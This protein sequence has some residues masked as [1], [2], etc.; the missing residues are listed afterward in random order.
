MAGRRFSL[1][2][3]LRR[4]KKTGDPGT[5]PAQQPEEMQQ[6]QPLQEDPGRVQTEEQDHAH[7]RFHR[8]AQAFLKFLGIR[9]TKTGRTPTEVMAQPDPMPK[10]LKAK[11]DVGTVSTDGTATC[12]TAVTDELMNTDSKP[13]QRLADAPSLD[14]VEES[15]VSA[16]VAVE[17]DR[18]MEQRP[19]RV[20]KLAWLKEGEEESP[21]P[22]PAQHPE[23]VEQFQP[24]QEEPGRVQTEEQDRAH[25]RFHR[26]A[27][28]FLKFL[29]IRRRKTGRTP[30]EVMAQ[31]DPTPKEL[32]AKPD[33]G[34][35]STDGT[36]TC[37]TAVTDELMNTDSKPVQRLADAPSLDFVEESV[38]SAQVAVEPDRGM[39]QRPPRVPKLAWLK[40]GEEESPG[41]APAQH[42]EDVEQFQPLQEDPGQVQTEEQDHAHGRFHRAA[43]AFLKFLGIRRTKT[44]RTPTEVM[45]QP[46][47]MPKELKAKPDVGTVSTDGTATCDTAVTD[48]L[49]NTDSKPV[50]RLADAPSLDFVEESVVSAQVAVEPDRGMEQRPP[51][52]P[53]LAWLKEGEEESPGPAPA[54]HPEDVEQFQPLQEEPGRVQTEEQ[55]RAHGRFHRAAQAFLKFLGIRRTKTGRTPTEVMAQPDPTPKEL[56]AKPDVGTVST[57]GTATCDTAVTDELMNTDSTPVQRLAD[58]PSLDFVEESVV[59][60]QVAVE[61]DRGMEQRPPRVPKL[62]WLKEGE[63]ESPGPAPAQHPEDVEQ[64]QPL[65]EEPGR[66]QTEEQDRAHGRFHRTAQAFLK[67]LGIRRTKTGRT[68]TEVMAQPDPTPKELK[69]K[70]DV[71]T[72]STDGTATCDTAVTDEL[73]NTDSTPVQ[74]LADAPSLDFVEESVVSAQVAVEPDR[75]ME[76]RPPRVPKLAWLKEGEEESPGPAPAQHPEDVEQFQPLQEDPGQ[77]QTEEQDRAHGRF[78]RTA[79]AFLKFL[80]IRRRKTGRTPTEVM[81]QPDPTPKELKAKP[82]VGTMSTDGTATCDTTVTDELMNTDS[83]PVQLLADAPS[84]DFVEESIVSAQVAM[85][86][87]RGMEQRPPRVPKLAWLKEGEEESPGPAPAQHPEDVEQFQPLQEDPGQVRKEEQD[88]ARGRFHRAAQAFLKFLGIRRTKTGRTPTEVMAQPDPTPKELKAKPDVGTVSTDGTATCDTAVTDELMNTDSTPVQHLADAPSLDFVEESVA[89]AQVAVEPDRGMEQRPPRVPKLAWLKEGEEESPGPA[90]AQHPEDVEQFQPLQEGEWQSWATGLV[91]AAT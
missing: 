47:P 30:T 40:E 34:T 11:P 70:P 27:Q 50:Q 78:H 77:V 65:Q 90:P 56:K 17:P 18:G 29:G 62:A 42:P 33:V 9:R 58:A 14:F 88:R 63:E 5:S 87:D 52:V 83:E 55:D 21:G 6:V 75:G 12:D 51:R 4:K 46:D 64:F 72:V 59:S 31:P 39:E 22:A 73:M 1:C 8:A 85:E 20:P 13:V 84:L 16:Q 89:S 7:G 48:E 35:V 45:A 36:A 19:P 61:P 37:D 81:A 76:Q 44:G 25:G 80:G 43:Q 86:P 74:R 32:K 53:K 67:F 23:D 91:A 3:V 26:A 41:P 38:V 10:E 15:V 69:A 24:L 68:P 82:D 28:A 71:G 60:A 49:M 57:D 2:R 79:Q 54:Q 66:V